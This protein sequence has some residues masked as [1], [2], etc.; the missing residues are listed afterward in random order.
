MI[1]EVVIPGGLV[2][3]HRKRPLSSF[4]KAP[5]KLV[6]EHA[7][8]RIHHPI[9]LPPNELQ[10]PSASTALLPQPSPHISPNSAIDIDPE[11]DSETEESSSVSPES[12]EGLEILGP[13]PSTFGSSELAGSGSGATV[14][15]VFQIYGPLKDA[16]TGA[17]LFNK[18]AWKTA[19]QILDLMYNGT[20]IWHV[21]ACLKDFFLRHNLLLSNPMDMSHWLNTSFYQ[22]TK[23]VIG[24]LPI[25]L[26]IQ[27]SSGISPW[28]DGVPPAVEPSM[29]NH[30]STR[31]RYLAKLQGT[32]KAVLPI[33]TRREH[34][35]F[36]EL[37]QADP[38][39]GPSLS[40]QP[41]W[42]KAV[43]TWKLES[44][45]RYKC[46]CVLQA[47]WTAQVPSYKLENQLEYQSD[48]V[49]DK[50]GLETHQGSTSLPSRMPELPTPGGN[51]TTH[52]VHEP[53]PPGPSRSQYN[54]SIAATA[55]S[56]STS[57]QSHDSQSDG[58]EISPYPQSL[59]TYGPFP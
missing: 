45:G 11:D 38:D 50:R 23:E 30:I 20:S 28:I 5:F 19:K 16:K 6:A 22:Q 9:V 27:Q 49:I 1:L 26:E 52:D 25:P 35:I 24:V 53:G 58:N 21:L 46:Q 32:R 57:S 54:Q 10:L 56:A 39:F 43:K 44:I 8:T 4:G 36:R 37:M 47:H 33:H 51:E 12:L 7:Y 17:T 40:A 42:D 31:H 48:D 34:E 2:N 59:S 18:A 15:K 29:T 41:N 55:M 3:S 14:S 13:M